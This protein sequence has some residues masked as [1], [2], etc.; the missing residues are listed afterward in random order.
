MAFDDADNRVYL[1]PLIDL[2]G[3]GNAPT[4]R[5]HP[6]QGASAE[7]EQSLNE[8]EKMIAV[9]ADLT[10][11][12]FILT[13]YSGP[14]CQVDYYQKDML[15]LYKNVVR[16]GGELAIHLD[17]GTTDDSAYQERWMALFLQCKYRLEQSGIAPVAYRSA[18]AAWHPFIQQALA[19]NEI[20]A[21]YSCFPAS[22]TP[23]R[24][25]LWGHAPLNASYLPENIQAPWR[26]QPRSNILEIPVGSDG[27]GGRV[28]NIL[29][30]EKS[31]LDNLT[32]IWDAIIARAEATA[33]C[34]IVHCLFHSSSVAVPDWLDRWRRFLDRVPHHQ[35]Q[36]I[37]TADAIA[38]KE[39][40]HREFA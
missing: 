23:S 31:S 6:Q 17:N 28:E 19:E 10:D 16:A 3:W 21:D 29:H 27:Q 30:I 37:T 36:F 40:F 7:I 4:N 39:R 12:R 32:R 5:R 38:L 20:F 11:S 25:A 8:A 33:E 24:R 22:N 15:A 34:Q 2:N 26:G 14:Q 1:V 18:D 35:G 9:M 13:P